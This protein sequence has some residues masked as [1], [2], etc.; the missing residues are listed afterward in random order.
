[1]GLN[2]SVEKEYDWEEA[3]SRRSKKSV[4]TRI[5]K[6]TDL[7]PR[8]QLYVKHWGTH[9]GIILK[10]IT[11]S[12]LKRMLQFIKITDGYGCYCDEGEPMTLDERLQQEWDTIEKEY[13]KQLE[14]STCAISCHTFIMD[15]QTASQLEML[16]S[17]DKDQKLRL[18]IWMNCVRDLLI[19]VI[20]NKKTNLLMTMFQYKQEL[21]DG[22]LYS[23]FYYRFDNVRWNA[24]RDWYNNTPM[25]KLFEH[26]DMTTSFTPSYNTVALMNH[27]WTIYELLPDDNK[28]IFKCDCYMSAYLLQNPQLYLM[29]EEF[30]NRQ[31]HN[32][33]QNNQQNKLSPKNWS[34]RIES[35][36]LCQKMKPTPDGEPLTYCLFS[37]AL[38]D[39][40]FDEAISYVLRDST[41]TLNYDICKQNHYTDWFKLTPMYSFLAEDKYKAVRMNVIQKINN[42][43]TDPV[44]KLNFKYDVYGMVGLL[45]AKSLKPNDS[46][47]QELER[48]SWI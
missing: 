40:K 20:I 3:E 35:Y 15:V 47:L 10:K 2:N 42:A 12:E 14:L 43:I 17:I 13:K 45:Y 19:D 26:Y 5:Y 37:S 4:V 25:R 1:M 38:K 34:D 36:V 28:L 27:L 6:V 31:F 23:K 46:M 32:Q 21:N 7:T 9:S 33:Q 18:D 16:I 30:F 8:E 44:D 48:I 29:C 11:D 39:G 24:E 22:T 41:N